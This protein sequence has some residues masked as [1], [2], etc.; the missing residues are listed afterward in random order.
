M[1][2]VIAISG[3]QRT[4]HTH[5]KKKEKHLQ[6]AGR[7]DSP[8]DDMQSKNVYFWPIYI[9]MDELR[10]DIMQDCLPT[11][12]ICLIHGQYVICATED[13][14]ILSKISKADY[15]EICKANAA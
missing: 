12:T 4:F 2:T 7:S 14:E 6:L 15:N 11:H 8:E 9:H 1:S 5:V 13:S 3:R 10:V